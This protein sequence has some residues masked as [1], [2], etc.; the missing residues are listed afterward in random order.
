MLSFIYNNI[1]EIFKNSTFVYRI[2]LR[3]FIDVRDENGRSEKWSY[4]LVSDCD[5]EIMN[6]L[7]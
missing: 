2:L 6:T 5:S 3:S 1:V 4:R 7:L